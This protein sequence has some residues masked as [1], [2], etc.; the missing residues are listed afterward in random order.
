MGLCV[1][2]LWVRG[3]CVRGLCVRGLCVRGLCVYGLVS[4]HVDVDVT[5]GRPPPTTPSFLG[6]HAFGP[7]R[8]T[9]RRG[10]VSP[11]LHV[12]GTGMSGGEQRWCECYNEGASQRRRRRW[13][14]C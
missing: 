8:C 10:R 3:L 6:E 1:R 5:R 2:G 13:C 12:Y 14:E 4:G 7:T 11:H 9:G